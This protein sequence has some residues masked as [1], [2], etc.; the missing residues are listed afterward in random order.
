LSYSL[1][2]L[3]LICALGGAAAWAEE[4]DA[5]ALISQ[6]VEAL[7]AQDFKRAHR[8]FLKAEKLAADESPEVLLGLT[9]ALL[10]LGDLTACEETARRLIDLAPTADTL[11]QAHLL[12]GVARMRSVLRDFARASRDNPPMEARDA[13]EIGLETAEGELRRAAETADVARRPAFLN[14]AYSLFWRNRFVDADLALRE[15]AASQ[16]DM[17]DPL[18]S[19]VLSCLSILQAEPGGLRNLDQ[20]GDLSPPSKRAFSLPPPEMLEG[21]DTLVVDGVVSQRGQFVCRRVVHGAVSREVEADLALLMDGWL[22]APAVLS[23]GTP[24]ASSYFLNARIEE[25]R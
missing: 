9:T 1:T 21:A 23:D 18:A 8:I 16:G 5:K 3:C 10:G 22:F 4:Q 24:T 7:Y 14:L 12:A 11:S 25:Q 6:G 2:A 13:L 19:R 17:L 15:F 20:L